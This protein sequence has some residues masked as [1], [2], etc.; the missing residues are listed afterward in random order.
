MRQFAIIGIGQFGFSVAK[1]LA[2]KKFQ[3]LAIDMD[4]LQIESVSSIVT[5]AVQADATD[6]KTLRALEIQQMDVG[7]VCLGNVEASILV[8]LL[9]KEMGVK[10]VVAKALTSL[11]AKVLRK[12]GVDRIIFPER[13]MGVRVAESLVSPNILEHIEL[14]PD[15]SIVEI[16]APTPFVGKSL[17]QINV[18]AKYGVSIIAIKRKIPY[19]DEAG[20]TGIKEEI[21]IAPEAEDEINE[22]DVL[23]VL[24]TAKNIEKLREH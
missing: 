2:Q 23:V 5:H 1:T 24:G 4:E 13:D 15:Y 22:G 6:E 8:S 21:N 11:H 18:R 16:V 12:V 17:K 3:V 10:M 7:I 20:D 14:S 9:L 19:I